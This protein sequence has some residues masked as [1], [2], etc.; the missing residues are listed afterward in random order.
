MEIDF[1]HETNYTEKVYCSKS[2][3]DLLMLNCVTAYLKAHPELK[4]TTIKQGHILR[5]VVEYYLK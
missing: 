3:K 4:G 2:T 5:Q 1:N